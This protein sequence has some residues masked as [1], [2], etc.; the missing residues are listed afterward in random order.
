M[1]S[2]RYALGKEFYRNEHV[3]V[4]HAVRL[5]DELPV[6][7]KIHTSAFP[8]LAEHTKLRQEF[9]FGVKLDLPGIIHYYE[10]ATEGNR[11]V[12]VMEDAG[13]ISLSAYL[14]RAE[15]DASRLELE[16]VLQIALSLAQTLEAV[17]RTGV[18][19][20]HIN[21]QHVLINPAAPLPK[22]IDF[23]LASPLRSERQPLRHGRI[24][25]MLTHVSPEQTGRTN[26]PVDERSDLYSLGICIYQLLTG[27]APFESDD[28]LEL[29]HCHLAKAPP[30]LPSSVP[31]QLSKLVMKLLAKAPDKRHASAAVLAADLLRVQRAL[32]HGSDS[33]TVPADAVP[34][35][36][37]VPERIYG[38]EKEKAALLDAFE[39]ASGGA[40]E[41][42]LIGGYSGIGKTSLV[43]EVQSRIAA[44][45]ANFIT[46]KFEQYKRNTP[47]A[48]FMIAFQEL[49]KQILSGSEEA[50]AYWKARISEAV[51]PNGQVL[52]DLIPEIEHLIGPQRE[53]PPLVGEEAQRRFNE[54]LSAF[55]RCLAAES[56]PLVIFLDDLQWADAGTLALIRVFMTAPDIRHLLLIGAYRDNEVNANHPMC[57]T[58]DDIR[59]AG[60]PVTALT[61]SPLSREAL[62]QLVSD[63]LQQPPDV[64]RDLATLIHEKTEGNPFFS[65]QLLTTLH[66]DGL[67]WFSRG[68]WRWSID[69]IR[70]A[71]LQ[72]NVI[73]LMAKRLRTLPGSTLESL[74]MAAC[75]GSSFDTHT[76][77]LVQGKPVGQVSAELVVALRGQFIVPTNELYKVAFVYDI[78]TIQ[79]DRIREL[80]AAATFRFLHD[81]VQQAAYS[82]I[83]ENELPDVHLKIGRLLHGK[84]GRRT[85]DENVFDIANH[86]NAG[87][88]RIDTVSEHYLAC[89]LNLEAAKRAKDSFAFEAALH[90]ASTAR[91]MLPQGAWR[92]RYSLAVTVHLEHSEAEFLNGRYVDALAVLDQATAHVD[93]ILDHGR[94]C[95]RKVL[96]YKMMNDL[97]KAWET[98]SAMLHRFG[99]ELDRSP[100]ERTLERERSLTSEMTRGRTIEEL[101]I[102]AHMDAPEQE[103]AC[104]ILQELWPVGFFLGSLG[105]H[106]AAMKIVQISAQHGNCG[107]SVFGYMA[108]AF[109]QVFSFMNIEDGY[110]MGKVS[111]RLHDRF[112]DRGVETKILDLWG[113]LIQHYKEPIREGRATLWQGFTRGLEFGDYQWAGYCAMN[114]SYL[115]VV[116]DVPLNEA[117]KHI[118]RVLP[119]LR[120]YDRNMTNTQLIVRETVSALV[121]TKA[122]PLIL[123]GAWCDEQ[124][125]LR[126]A[127]ENNEKY[128]SFIVY[129]HK[130]LLALVFGRREALLDCARAASET[131][132]GSAGIWINPVFHYLHCLAYLDVYDT[133][134][135]DERTNAMSIIHRNLAKIATWRGH[136]PFNYAHMEFLIRAEF[137]RVEGHPDT[138]RLYEQAIL[139]ARQNGFTHD[140]G[141]ACERAARFYSEQ[142]A[143][144]AAQR[145]L[146]EA[147]YCYERWGASAKVA[148]LDRRFPE[149]AAQRLGG[150][151]ARKAA[152]DIDVLSIMKAAQAVS[153]S[154]QV[155]AVLDN[156]LAILIENAGA[157]FGALVTV[158]DEGLEKSTE[159]SAGS[160]ENL[161]RHR[162]I[163]S[164][165]NH[166]GEAPIRES[167]PSDE[168]ELL[169]KGINVRMLKYAIRTKQR[170]LIN[171]TSAEQAGPFN[172]REFAQSTGARSIVVLPIV[173]Q[174][175]VRTVAVLYNQTV[176][177]AFTEDRLEVL[178]LLSSQASLA[179]HNARLFAD[180]ESTS[181][182]LQISHDLLEEYSRTLEQKV[183][184]RTREI[185]DKNA[186]LGA[187]IQQLRGTQ[188]QLVM[189]EKL[190]SLG[191]LTAGIAHEI[192]NPLNFVMNFAESVV[193][194]AGELE[195]ELDPRTS[196]LPAAKQ[197]VVSSGLGDLREAAGK[198]FTHGKRAAQIVDNMLQHAR[199]GSGNREGTDLNALLTAA[200]QLAITGARANDP[201]FA[202]DL[203]ME[204]DPS[205]GA[206]DAVASDMSRVFGNL[207][208][209]A[210]Y[211]LR[212]KRTESQG[213]HRPR[214]TVRSVN[215]GGRVEIRIRDNG[216][217]IP[218]RVK[219][220]IFE[221]FFTTKPAGQ[222][223]GLGLSLSRE[224][225]VDGH[226]GSLDVDT[227]A[228]EYTEFKVTLPRK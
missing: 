176:A 66:Q 200:V 46:G 96:L 197:R 86:Y 3:R 72:T 137:G 54:T 95:E 102:Q 172:L 214:L 84:S 179:L 187:A 220:Q 67:I 193:E 81:R 202:I 194:L 83:P 111:L 130:L 160:S 198:I 27:R 168:R 63:A 97:N 35:P 77:A 13:G 107:A 64:T 149:L 108:Y 19:H 185:S 199:T 141:L 183:E 69:G 148:Q 23:G 167:Q 73:E 6:V 222:G 32:A 82:L 50:L 39:R 133:L 223:T 110:K 91:S 12:L 55:V 119:T 100:D 171:D 117:I 205:I 10:L 15:A 79:D 53:A 34:E 87:R 9:E 26:Y 30:P 48:S 88:D 98:G 142:G 138:M 62:G 93:R 41:L 158:N 164:V 212:Q 25:G 181:H 76:L 124:E 213:E 186:E 134:S 128:T 151:A 126:Y 165:R 40:P 120:K 169:A 106:V 150:T 5:S 51:G 127:E 174:D 47:Y 70:E 1:T 219:E 43:F 178:R 161:G 85:N 7:L 20:K 4:L 156:L 105:M 78:E 175:G 218:E 132:A 52:T 217:G 22:L 190:A 103:A 118:D 68:A 89:E 206:I 122:D 42:L 71:G 225:I 59:S 228:G 113:G 49:V 92:E 104:R 90:Y 21:S 112:Q 56:H 2:T 116:G 209:N 221:P 38:R 17:H 227:R 136:A 143:P 74:R 131:V 65:H 135:P 203:D 8:T 173:D 191:A 154:L 204:L 147:R 123:T 101:A 144:T 166:V 210:C 162:F 75:I 57:V 115:C 146:L 61:L 45:R 188:R 109:A 184:E 195:T 155:N 216:T 224:I 139:A 58:I 163:V 121:E 201:T 170:V 60:A 31:V 215:H 129:F 114:Y 11:M 14:R 33:L 36:F 177:N 24:E 189:Q 18:V 157:T 28:P 196:A 208:S 125:M 37:H 94:I 180:L 29:I 145:Y 99:V 211:A 140:Q 16:S 207:L 159:E 152:P 182:R 153:S 80:G 44:R 226:Q 192:K